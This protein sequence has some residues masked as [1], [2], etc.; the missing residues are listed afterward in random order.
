MAISGT[1]QDGDAV[2]Y[3]DCY[4]EVDVEGN[5]SWAPLWSWATE[6]ALS[7][8]DVPTTETF[9]FGHDPI[10]FTG[11]KG[12][13]DVTVTAVYTEGTNDPF[14][15]IRARFESDPGGDFDVRFVPKGSSPGNKMFSTNGGKLTACPPPVGAG[16]A[17]SATVFSF[18]C[19]GR[20]LTQGALGS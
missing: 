8:E 16:D 2:N 17:S 7:G 20:G 10:V 12:A 5:G 4:V 13:I 9:P 14:H 6:V 18:T 11:R 19:R 3:K 15:N 1:Y